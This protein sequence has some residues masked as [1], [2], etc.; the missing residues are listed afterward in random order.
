MLV[1]FLAGRMGDMACS[2]PSC[3]VSVYAGEPGRGA[4]RGS[5]CGEISDNLSGSLWVLGISLIL[6]GGCE[7]GIA[8]AGGRIS[9]RG[10][11]T[12]TESLETS[13]KELSGKGL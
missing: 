3:R 9:M 7:E 8:G 2:L 5:L 10:P 4:L 6:W 1:R 11:A 12:L 13:M